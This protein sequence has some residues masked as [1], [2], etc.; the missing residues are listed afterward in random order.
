VSL[1]HLFVEK[2]C[3]FWTKFFK[4]VLRPQQKVTF[5]SKK[6][7]FLL[8]KCELG[9]KNCSDHPNSWEKVPFSKNFRK[10]CFKKVLRPQEKVTFH[11]KKCFFYLKSVNFSKVCKEWSPFLLRKSAIFEQ[12]VQKSPTSSTKSN[13][14]FK[15]L[16]F[17]L[18]KCELGAKKLLGSP[19]SLR[20][21]AIFKEFSKKLLQKSPTS[22]RK[23]TFCSKKCFFRKKSAFFT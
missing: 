22:S 15:K 6:C 14:F 17:L 1:I 2:K 7:L 12:N 23:G 20:K 5:C 18:K 4:K 9:A 16:L 8:K 3:H 19:E 11:S 21:S 10:N 13:F